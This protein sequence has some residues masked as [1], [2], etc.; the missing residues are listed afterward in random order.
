MIATMM[1]CL[2]KRVVFM[3]SSKLAFLLKSTIFKLRDCAHY[4]A[5]KVTILRSAFGLQCVLSFR[6]MKLF[7][8]ILFHFYKLSTD[9]RCFKS[10]KGK[11]SQLFT[12]C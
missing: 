12:K 5:Q 6:T 8:R 1:K 7:L 9:A 10:T 11:Q 4:S 3:T 2:C